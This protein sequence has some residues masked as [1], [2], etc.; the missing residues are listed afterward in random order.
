MKLYHNMK[1]KKGVFGRNFI[2]TINL[3]ITFMLQINTKY[4]Q[5]L[6]L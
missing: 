4:L 3:N 1:K 5:G 2:L 6:Y